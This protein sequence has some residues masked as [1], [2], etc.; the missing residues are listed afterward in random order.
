MDKRILQPKEIGYYSRPI[1]NN[2]DEDTL[3]AYIEEAE[4]ADIRKAIGDVFYQQILARMDTEEDPLLK[5]LLEGGWYPHVFDKTFDATFGEDQPACDTYFSGLKKTIAYYA[6]AKIIKGN[7]L[8]VTRF[9]LVHKDGDYSTRPSAS[10]RNAQY[11][12]ISSIADGY[13]AETLEYLRIY[14]DRYPHF[15]K[16]QGAHI[17]NNRTKFRVIGN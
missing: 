6:L 10:E 17:K 7:D 14:S 8:Q 3:K 2:M 4:D 13:L 11:R 16:C 1:S 5:I 15:K 12:D 9:G